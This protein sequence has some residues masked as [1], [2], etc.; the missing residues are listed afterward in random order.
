MYAGRSPPGVRL[1]QMLFFVTI[2]ES[3]SR[4]DCLRFI[5]FLD[6]NS[7]KEALDVLKMF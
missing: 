3:R 6:A 4:S 5:K 1:E 7:K 2:F